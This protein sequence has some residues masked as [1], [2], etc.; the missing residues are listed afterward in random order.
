MS[1]ST[2]LLPVNFSVFCSIIARPRIS[3]PETIPFKN[4]SK[5]NARPRIRRRRLFVVITLMRTFRAFASGK[6]NEM[7]SLHCEAS[8]SVAEK[9]VITDT[10]C[11][12]QW[13]FLPY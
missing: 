4:I 11:D 2:L 12:T 1:F 5:W 13:V 9:C 10:R 3:I 7:K 6:T 8:Q